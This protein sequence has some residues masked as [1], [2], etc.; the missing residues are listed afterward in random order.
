MKTININDKELK[1]YEGGDD[2]FI[3]VEYNSQDFDLQNI[4]YRNNG[5]KKEVKATKIII[6]LENSQILTEK[7]TSSITPTGD[8]VDTKI[9]PV[10]ITSEEDTQIFME[11]AKALLVPALLNGIVRDMGV[12]R[13]VMDLKGKL[14]KS[15]PVPIPENVEKE[16]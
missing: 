11:Q 13:A 2:G 5:L 6:D 9:N 7:I 10:F 15:Q 1:L 8:K 14:I 12:T 16:G 4:F 3:G